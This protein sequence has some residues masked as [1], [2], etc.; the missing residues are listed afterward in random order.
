MQFDSACRAVALYGRFILLLQ[1]PGFAF[2]WADEEVCGAKHGQ[3][4]CV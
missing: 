3:L 4:Y 2:L 1:A